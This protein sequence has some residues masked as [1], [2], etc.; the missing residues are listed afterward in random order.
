MSFLSLSLEN[1]QGFHAGGGR[2]KID[3]FTG[4]VQVL[5]IWEKERSPLRKKKIQ[6]GRK[7]RLER[8]SAVSKF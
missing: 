6:K 4:R 5:P 8:C 1:Q 7:E 2:L 3:G